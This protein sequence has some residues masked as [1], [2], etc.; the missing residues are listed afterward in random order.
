M[1]EMNDTDDSPDDAYFSNTVFYVL[2]D[3]LLTGLTM[4][5]NADKKLAE[6]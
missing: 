4:R 6:N 5:L 2:I 1:A 3:C